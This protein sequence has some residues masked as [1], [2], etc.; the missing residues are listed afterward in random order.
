MIDYRIQNFVEHPGHY[1]KL[2]DQICLKIQL[3]ELI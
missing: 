1:Q 2:Q 3:N